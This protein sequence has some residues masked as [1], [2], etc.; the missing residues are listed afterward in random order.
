[1]QIKLNRVCQMTPSGM[2]IT[3]VLNKHDV[4]ISSHLTRFGSYFDETAEMYLGTR[5]VDNFKYFT[6]SSGYFYLAG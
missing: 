1:M 2:C 6:G 5:I 4:L 3:E